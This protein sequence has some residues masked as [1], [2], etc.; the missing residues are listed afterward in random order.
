MIKDR[1]Q[2]EMLYKHFRAQGWLAQIEVPVIPTVGVSQKAHSITDIDVLG[3]RHFDL[4]WHYVIGDCKTKKSESPVN[5]VLWVRGLIEVIGASSAV[6]LLQRQAGT[7]IDRDHKLVADEQN[8]L[9]I[10]ESEFPAYDRAIIYPSGSASFREDLT[11]IEAIREGIPVNFPALALLS[12]WLLSDSWAITDHSVLLRRSLVELS[13]QRGELDPRRDDHLALI[14]EG[15]VVFSVAFAT[16]VGK[17]FRRHIQPEDRADLDEAI[18]VIIWGGR[19]QYEFFTKLRR[20]V[21]NA[22]GDEMGQLG[23]P[24]W[25][26]FL[27]LTRSLLEAPRYAFR[28]PHFLRRLSTTLMSN[29]THA[30]L[31][32]DKTLL[33]FTLKLTEYICRATGMPSDASARIRGLLVPRMTE[34]TETRTNSATHE[35]HQQ[36]VLFRSEADDL[37]GVPVK[38]GQSSISPNDDDPFRENNGVANGSIGDNSG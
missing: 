12:S 23:L 5:R 28:I 7:W 2:K 4:R 8:V 29:R 25:T 16:L 38:S 20:Q 34:L 33:Q 6:V 32:R 22:S 10:Q 21:I 9:L 30:V 13:D 15:C 36:A 35:Q 14:L 19:E 18:R 37:Q 3:I 24:E 17:I 1:N 27:E 31:E 26:R 11:T